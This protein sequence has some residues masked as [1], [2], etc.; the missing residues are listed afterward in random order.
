MGDGK[1]LSP[2]TQWW[3]SGFC[4]E[5]GQG[6]GDRPSFHPSNLPFFHVAGINFARQPLSQHS[7]VRRT[8][9]CCPPGVPSLSCGLLL[10]AEE[11]FCMSPNVIVDR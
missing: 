4:S 2:P 10:I 5:P 9:E 7:V 8:G 1:C 11:K 3:P 6:F